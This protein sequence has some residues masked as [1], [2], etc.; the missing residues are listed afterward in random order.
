MGY[1]RE[2]TIYKLRHPTQGEWGTHFYETFYKS[3]GKKH[4]RVT[5]RRGVG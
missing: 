2:L 3:K 5:K 4:L 1:E